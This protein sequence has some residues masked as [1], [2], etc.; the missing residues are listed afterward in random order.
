M[1]TIEE[2]LAARIDGL[3]AKRAQ[4]TARLRDSYDNGTWAAASPEARKITRRS[5][6][7]VN[8][9]LRIALAE[10]AAW[11]ENRNAS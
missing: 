2:K 10:S 11:H 6:R 7:L 5:F 8:G 4:M 1:I 9:Q 3:L